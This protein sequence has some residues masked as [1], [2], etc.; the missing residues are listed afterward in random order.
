ME[1]QCKIYEESTTCSQIEN[2]TTLAFI[3]TNLSRVGRLTVVSSLLLLL[4]LRRAALVVILLIVLAVLASLLIPVLL[5]L[6]LTRLRLVVAVLVSLLKENTKHVSQAFRK[7]KFH[8]TLPTLFL[9]AEST[10]CFESL[11]YKRGYLLIGVLSLI[12]V[13]R[14]AV[15]RLPVFSR[16]IVSVA[17]ITLQNHSAFHFEHS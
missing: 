12:R 4:L 2:S 8:T 7:C 10:F 17:V 14:A 5:L 9:S 3:Q 13:V 6:L 11:F 1:L 15:S 16:H